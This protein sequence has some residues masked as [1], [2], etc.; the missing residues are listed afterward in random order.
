MAAWQEDELRFAE[1]SIED[2]HRATRYALRELNGFTPWFEDLVRSQPDAVRNVLMQCISGEWNTAVDSEQHYLALYKLASS[3]SGACDLIKPA[4]IKRLA[5]DEPKNPYVLQFALCV[6]VAQSPPSPDILAKMAEQRASAVPVCAPSFPKWMALWLQ[7]DAVSALAVLE[8]RLASAADG[9]SV[10]S[11]ICANL[12]GRSG[13]R[14]ALLPNP[15]W[16]APVAMKRFIPLVY[17]YIRPEDDI[18]RS[19]GGAYS[20]TARDDAQDFRGGLLERMIATG[21]PDVGAALK[22][23]LLDPLLSHLSDYLKRLLEKHREQFADGR[24]W[25]ASDVRVFATA[26]E[27][28]P[29]TDADLFRIGVRRLV[30]LKRW[31]ESGEDSPREEVNPDHNESGFRRWLQRRLSEHARGRYL[32]PQEWEI[33]GM[34]RPDL[35]LA[36]PATGISPVSLELKIVD[37]RPLQDLLAGLETQLVGTYLRDHRARYGI[38][39][40]ALFRREKTWVPLEGGPRIDCEQMLA[41]LRNRVEE[42]LTARA[43][44]AGLEVVLIHFSPPVR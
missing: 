34:A 39:V 16:L 27:R 14:L 15:S 23:L 40:L 24:P 42:I 44:I 4:L 19:G 33:D 41:I 43:D 12:G 5:E 1:L 11:S 3:E 10:M 17:R 6:L 25:R 21:H 9:T 37:E 13:H 22:E 20:P 2:A 35:R 29:Q 7:A 18:N 26:Y 8:S 36:S 32:V 31:V 38:Y 30:D 28:E